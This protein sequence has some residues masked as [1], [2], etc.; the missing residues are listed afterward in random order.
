MTNTGVAQPPVPPPCDALHF[1]KVGRVRVLP[2][3]AVVLQHNG[4]TT[5]SSAFQF[6]GGESLDKPGLA[7]WRQRYRVILRDLSNDHHTV[8]LKRYVRPPIGQQFR[9]IFRGRPRDSTAGQEWRT[10]IRLAAAGIPVP[11]PV[12]FGQEMRGWFERR[13]FLLLE[14]VAGTSLESW[15][16]ENWQRCAA[17][18]TA[19]RQH[20]FVRRLARHVAALH[21]AGFV[22]RDLYASHIFVRHDEGFTFID[23]QRVFRPRWRRTRWVIKDLA[24]LSFST[25]AFAA[26]TDRLRFWREYVR[27]VRR[28]RWFR[29]LP[30]RIEAKAQRI[31]Q[32]DAR[33][34]ARHQGHTP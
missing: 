15:M 27:A 10:I 30:A 4:L 17:R 28:E 18:E 34:L 7:T 12:A 24:A 1:L 2:R 33:R 29:A 20:D 8:Y 11:A 31:R 6:T 26:P 25:A 9:R 32:H 3:Y 21:A 16:P 5:F 22:H 13:S 14:A 19:R 23:L